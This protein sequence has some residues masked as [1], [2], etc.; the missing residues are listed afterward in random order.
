MQ[1]YY[2]LGEINKHYLREN[3]DNFRLD[4]VAPMVMT[5][6][7]S[8]YLADAKC[9]SNLINTRER[10]AEVLGFDHPYLWRMIDRVRTGFHG[11]VVLKNADGT[12]DHVCYLVRRQFDN[13]LSEIILR[14]SGGTE[15]HW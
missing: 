8:T 11:V 14:S 3:P 10:L 1:R 4:E 2:H 12:L 15:C 6:D 9:Y 13:D 5:V 7:G